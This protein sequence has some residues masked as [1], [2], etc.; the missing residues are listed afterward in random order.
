MKQHIRINDQVF[1]VQELCEKLG[2]SEPAEK[3]ELRQ[4]VPEGTLSASLAPD[5]P[6]DVYPGIDLELHLSASAN[7]LPIMVARCERPISQD[8]DQ[9]GVR[10]YLFSRQDEYFAYSE[11]DTRTDEEV[12]SDYLAP[13]IVLSGNPNSVARITLENNYCK[14]E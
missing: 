6:D 14:I 8:E 12:D 10:T 11:L 3:I 4:E 2:I 5:C 13:T 7:S 9:P 1:T